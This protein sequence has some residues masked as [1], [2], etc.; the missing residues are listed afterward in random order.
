MKYKGKSGKI[1]NLS[2]LIA[3]GGEGM[4]YD[5]AENCN[6]VAK[7]YK[8]GKGKND[9]AKERKLIAM[10]NNPP[11]KSVL[12]QITWP[13]DILYNSSGIFVGFIMLKLT[14]NEDLNVIYEYGDDAKYK[15]IPW[16]NKIIVAENI[17]AVL[18]AVHGA[19]HVV[20]DLNPKNISVDPKT[21]Y[22]IFVDTDS[23]HIKNSDVIYR[24]EVGMS[25]YLPPEL[26]KA[27]K[28]GQSL[29]TA[30]LPTFTKATDNFALAVHIFQLL[31]NGV[32]PFACRLLPDSNLEDCPQP[33]DN[34]LKGVCPFF[35][36]TQGIDIP[37][38]APPITILPKN[39]QDLFRRAFV[40]GYTNPNARPTAAKWHSA[41]S[42][43]AGQLKQCGVVSFHEYYKTLNQCPWCQVKQK[44]RSAYSNIIPQQHFTKTTVSPNIPTHTPAP[45]APVSSGYTSSASSYSYSGYSS[46]SKTKRIVII[47]LLV[48]MLVVGAVVLI[49]TL[50]ANRTINLSVPTSLRVN[51]SGI[52]WDN[53]ENA[54]S[55]TV[56]INNL[57]IPTLQNFILIDNSFKAA[58][59]NISVKA[60]GAS[61]NKV[62][63]DYSDIITVTKPSAPA[64]I[65]LENGIV[66]W[67]TVDNYELYKVVVNGSAVAT[68]NGVEYVLKDNIDVLQSGSNT[69]AV[70]VAGDSAS[71][72][73]SDLS[74]SVEAV[75]LSAPMNLSIVDDVLMWHE[76]DGAIGYSVTIANESY[77]ATETVGE[78]I[79]S[80]DL[81]GKVAKGTYQILV[82]A[83]GD[84]NT[85]FSSEASN[86]VSYT[87][88][89]VIITL[90]TKSDLLNMSNDSEAT[91]ILQND[92]DISGV[93]WT[94]IGTSST[95]FNGILTGNGYTINGLTI[96]SAE[97]S[98]IGF[99]GVI[100]ESGNVDGVTFKDVN[101]SGS[102]AGYIGA[103]AGISYGTISNVTVS[104]TVGYSTSG[105]NVGGLVGASYGFIYN[106]TSK[107]Q[108]K[109][110][111][112]VGGIVGSFEF[113]KANM[114]FNNCVN[115]GTIVG[116]SRV[117]GLVGYLRVARKNNFFSLNNVGS[118]TASDKYAGGI[119]GYTEGSSGQTGY[120][121]SCVNSG[122][123]IASDYVGGC[124]GYVG[125]Y[126]NIT[127]EDL[128]SSKNCSNT[129]SLYSNGSHKGTIK[130]N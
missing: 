21:G 113:S 19:G 114:S 68:V 122:T 87:S 111:T 62:D 74:S 55:Y 40:D 73:D 112:N 29:K 69:I 71:V 120:Y 70:S 23:Y 64:S 109:G 25:E 51:D 81:S 12:S 119:C 3:Q 5:V 9:T 4:I 75:K 78:N 128:D 129:G 41:L 50:R 45:Q 10:I 52:S 90:S 84:G 57:E 126:I 59:F 43:L 104:G 105:D 2:N 16:K 60:N 99:F 7:L 18:D 66:S 33:T 61:D 54:D 82:Q 97:V 125:V 101:I 106:C 24:C 15:N 26:Q 123:I 35:Q 124:F 83:L 27:L 107:A 76:I 72:V 65:V 115:Y 48:L 47:S 11:D 34:I 6:L 30:K 44:V 14:I 117:G 127:Y 42:V 32:H 92:I 56:K 116:Q 93:D 20:G 100:G 8:D 96:K 28:G 95:K 67:Q 53:V 38:F 108:V 77:S 110:A 37:V 121:E 79:T 88:D 46:G 1:Y 22:V 31:M 13:Q 63:S 58:T 39:V 85:Y 118:V 17:C 130:G 36:R 49:F 80:L 103:V 91:Y 98:N 89:K 86:T 102:S 94:P